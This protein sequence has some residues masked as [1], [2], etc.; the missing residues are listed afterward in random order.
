MKDDFLSIYVTGGQ[1]RLITPYEKLSL[2]EGDCIY[3]PRN[4]GTYQ[5]IGNVELLMSEA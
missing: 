5:V 4:M 1:G 2:T 3:L